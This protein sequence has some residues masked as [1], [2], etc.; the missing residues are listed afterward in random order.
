V[1]IIE[2][3][4]HIN[5]VKGLLFAQGITGYEPLR[6]DRRERLE[7]LRTG[8]GRILAKHVRAQVN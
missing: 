1:L 2:R 5:R 8:D 3:T 7:D 6:R 4:Q